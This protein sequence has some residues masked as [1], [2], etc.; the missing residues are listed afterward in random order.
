MAEQEKLQAVA[1][2]EE[3]FLRKLFSKHYG[4]GKVSA[5]K[6]EQR[7][8]GF[9]GWE[10][11]IEFRHIR[12]RNEEELRARLVSEA[13]LY[14]SHSVGYYEFPEARPM[15][16]KNWLG[17]DLVFDL[18]AEGH[19]CG[20]FT[21]QECLDKVKA[22]AMKLIDEFLLPDFG[23]SK[24]EISVNFSGSRGYHVHVRSGSVMKL[25]RE[26]RREIADY[27]SG[28]GLAFG[29]L[30]WTEGKK[31]FGPS[32]SQ[33]GYGGKFA[34]AFVGRLGD[35]AFAASVSRKLKKREEREK[36]VSSIS[37]GN[38]DSIGIA[39][40]EA[41]LAE[42]FEEMKL[43]MAGRIDANVTADTTKL[44]RMPDSLH[45]GSGLSAKRM[46]IGELAAFDP[47]RDAQ[48]FTQGQLKIRTS[49]AVT[50]VPHLVP[51]ALGAGRALELPMASAVYLLCKKAAVLA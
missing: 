36:L 39:N 31:L 35:E 4:R 27:V 3:Q 24:G 25:D 28:T 20:K 9:G 23:F 38:W 10:K 5:L 18:D 8:F 33:G 15:P 21:C 45:G 13:P 29:R 30:F 51:E 2:P 14:V 50:A 49:E 47:M 42:K 22:D 32:P 19:S 34:R 40:R 43:T 48:V 46:G 16:R 11:K 7:E 41:R 12:V 17:A 6:P 26:A 1:C 44:I 37:R